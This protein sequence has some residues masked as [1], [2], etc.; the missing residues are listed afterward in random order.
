MIDM[1][2][3]A[4]GKLYT[5]LT[6]CKPDDAKIKKRLL[7][8]EI[9]EMPEYRALQK[10]EGADSVMKEYYS[11]GKLKEATYEQI[12]E[13]RKIIPFL[14][15][16]IRNL[17]RVICNGEVEMLYK[18]QKISFYH[19]DSIR[20]LY[21]L[22]ILMKDIGIN[23]TNIPECDVWSI[24]SEDIVLSLD[25]KPELF[26]FEDIETLELQVIEKLNDTVYCI[27]A[28]EIAERKASYRENVRKEETEKIKLQ[29][30]ENKIFVKKLIWSFISIAAVT[31]QF[32]E[33][34]VLLTDKGGIAAF[35]SYL[36]VLIAYWILG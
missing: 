36:I 31:Y 13:V 4:T 12:L 20:Y 15:E 16:C 9:L 8:T 22:V 32:S 17:Y 10:Y 23:F 18:L 19:S 7:I 3:T 29:I 5:L 11:P 6:A 24:F 34:A 35:V 2:K 1:L 25:D 33:R 26:D 14:E 27:H 30:V 28:E 21:E